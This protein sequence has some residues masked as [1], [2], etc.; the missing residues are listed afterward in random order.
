M[1]S[2]RA[3]RAAGAVLA[4]LAAPIIA[5]CGTDQSNPTR[6]VSPMPRA[7]PQGSPSAIETRA[8]PVG[9]PAGGP[10]ENADLF[11]PLEI[12]NT[13]THILYERTTLLDL[14]GARIASR[15]ETLIISRSLVREW[16]Y[17]GREYV[18]EFGYFRFPSLPTCYPFSSVVYRQDR[19]GL[20]AMYLSMESATRL[21]RETAIPSG[22]MSRASRIA[23][24]LGGRVSE[25]SVV[26]HLS[27]TFQAV[28]GLS[29]T[30]GA[31]GGHPP[32][33]PV[34]LESTLLRYP[35]HPGAHWMSRGDPP[36]EYTVQALGP[37]DEPAGRIVGARI[38]VD[39]EP[40]GPNG[41]SVVWYSREGYLGGV[42]HVESVARDE[43]GASVGTILSDADERLISLSLQPRAARGP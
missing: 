18:Q 40:L 2:A 19:S 13:W 1:L 17:Y 26:D 41:I 29:L 12:G 25:R 5:G 24:S 10:E 3:L 6:F 28:G 23:A 11:Y 39:W 37:V 31:G 8:V 7:L 14:T 32:G 27:H 9:R 22:L 30:A 38:R 21:T 35:L 4:V 15:A 16:S 42:S 36:P 34:G 43:S 20:Y 33:G